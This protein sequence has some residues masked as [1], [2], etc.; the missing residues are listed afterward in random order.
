MFITICRKTSYS[1]LT[2]KLLEGVQKYAGHKLKL[3][4]TII[5]TLVVICHFAVSTSTISLLEPY[6]DKFERLTMMMTKMKVP[7]GVIL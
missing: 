6:A 3:F 4:S 1:V 7:F 2:T 5:N